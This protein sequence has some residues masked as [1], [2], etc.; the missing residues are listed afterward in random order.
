MNELVSQAGMRMR[1]RRQGWSRTRRPFSG[2]HGFESAFLQHGVC[3]E[4][5]FFVNIRRFG[6]VPIA[7]ADSAGSRVPRAT[8]S[9]SAFQR[10]SSANAGWEMMPRTLSY[11][12]VRRTKNRTL[13]GSDQMNDWESAQPLRRRGDRMRRR[14]FITLIAGSAFA[15]PVIAHAQQKT[16]PVI[17]FLQQ[18]IAQRLC[19][20]GHGL[21][22]RSE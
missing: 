4:P 20:A 6:P 10:A 14:E 22:Q 17:G 16:I 8:A 21:S 12:Q 7:S 11:S 19:R 1:A 2:D 18:P 3:C 13:G 9:R 15:S 5:N